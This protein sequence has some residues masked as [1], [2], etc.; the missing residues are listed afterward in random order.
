MIEY[1]GCPK[2][3]GHLFVAGDTEGWH[4][5]CLNCGFRR[6]LNQ[7]PIGADLCHLYNI[8]RPPVH[9]N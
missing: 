6:D 2:C 9:Q 7:S 3:S 1:G 4:M 8:E 5:V